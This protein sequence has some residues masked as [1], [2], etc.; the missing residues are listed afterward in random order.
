[1]NADEKLIFSYTGENQ[2]YHTGL[3]KRVLSSISTTTSIRLQQY[4][5]PLSKSLSDPKPA[6]ERISKYFNGVYDN[7]AKSFSGDLSITTRTTAIGGESGLTTITYTMT[8]VL[9]ARLVNGQWI[10]DV[11]GNATLTSDLARKGRIPIQSHPIPLPGPSP[12]HPSSSFSR[13]L[14]V[15]G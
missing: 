6:V 15:F 10:G 4:K 11:T 7:A 1:M 2:S 13:L 5:K 9:S 8:G 3:R 12:A 14:P